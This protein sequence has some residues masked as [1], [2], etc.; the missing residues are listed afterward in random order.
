VPHYAISS[1]FILSISSLFFIV[2]AVALL[3]LAQR[4][5][6]P[7]VVLAQR[8]LAPL[9]VLAQRVLAPLALVVLAQRVLA[10][11]ALVVL[12]QRVL[13]LLVLALPALLLVVSGRREPLRRWVGR[14][15]ERQH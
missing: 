2:L 14:Q 10:P 12:A 6:A 8:V 11:L 7:L 13:A 1:L 15:L 4:A 3:A 5:L 9:V